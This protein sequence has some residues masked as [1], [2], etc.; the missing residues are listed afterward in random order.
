MYRS[1]N[2][3]FII[4]LTIILGIFLF[5]SNK[6][7][8]ITDDSFYILSAMQFGNISSLCIELQ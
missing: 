6:G 5:N 2:Y 7:F 4:L 8:D 3:F 1:L